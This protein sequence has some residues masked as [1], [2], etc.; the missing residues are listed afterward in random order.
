MTYRTAADFRTALESRLANQA[1]AEGMVDPNRLR[2]S[3]A[4]ER[5]LARLFHTG[6]ERWVLKGGYALELRFPGR[7]RATRDLDLNVPPPPYPELL[8]ELQ[9][10]AEVDLKDYFE[11]VVSTSA[12]KGDLAGPPLGGRRFSVQTMLAGRRFVMF[13]VDVGQGDVTVRE[14]DRISGRMDLRFA[15]ID[16]P[17]FPVYPLEDHFAEKLHAYTAPHEFRTRVKDL[18][19][20]LLLIEQGLPL[21]AHLRE[22][23]RTTFDR[24]AR[25]PLP[26]VLPLPPPEWQRTFP[27]MAKALDLPVTD[28]LQAYTILQNFLSRLWSPNA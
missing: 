9:V 23:I 6:M 25:H 17:W 10:A 11:F 22:S 13:P 28:H 4:F 3:V 12:S 8:N 5:F 24:Y 21:S 26:S 20:M 15:G 14:P 7:A 19:D 27:A 16:T 2:R 1:R 18:I